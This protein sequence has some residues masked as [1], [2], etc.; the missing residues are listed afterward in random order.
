M[1]GSCQSP[2]GPPRRPP[3]Q[4]EAL[5]P[6]SGCSLPHPY[7][8]KLTHS[9]T[10]PLDGP[11]AGRVT[12]PYGLTSH[13][14]FCPSPPALVSCHRVLGTAHCTLCLKFIPVSRVCTISSPVASHSRHGLPPRPN[15]PTS[16]SSAWTWAWAKLIAIA[17]DYIISMISNV[18]CRP[19]SLERDHAVPGW[20]GGGGCCTDILFRT[21]PGQ[22]ARIL[23]GRQAGSSCHRRL[24]H[25]ARHRFSAPA[26]HAQPPAAGQAGKPADTGRTRCCPSSVD[27]AMCH[28]VVKPQDR[29]PH[30][31]YVGWWLGL[32][33]RAGGASVA[34]RWALGRV[35]PC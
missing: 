6:G 1:L 9:W 28:I 7:Q 14:V 25:T 33:P 22:R 19:A 4:L 35:A 8:S 17:T 29:E 15:Q 18:R 24:C 27:E 20:G 26:K 12:L 3:A 11:L 2:Q 32:N 31:V 34:G 30:G 23:D 21:Q 13:C 10:A 5:G 16:V